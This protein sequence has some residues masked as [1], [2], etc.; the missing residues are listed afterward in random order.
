MNDK[1]SQSIDT[2]N[3]RRRRE[4]QTG[5]LIFI[6]IQAVV[7]LINPTI[8]ESQSFRIPVIVNPIWLFK[9]NSNKLCCDCA[10]S[11]SALSRSDLSTT[12]IKCCINHSIKQLLSQPDYNNHQTDKE[13]L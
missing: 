9:F 1:R 13:P 8:P 3:E 12:P 10:S 11:S 6:I 7:E 4:R 2:Q 5:I